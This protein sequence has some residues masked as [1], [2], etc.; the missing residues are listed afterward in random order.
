[1]DTDLRY[2]TESEDLDI[3]VHAV[4]RTGNY[5]APLRLAR[6]CNNAPQAGSLGKQIQGL[7]ERVKNGP[8]GTTPVVV[9]ST[10]YQP[11]NPQSSIARLFARLYER[12]G[13]Y[14]I[15]R[16]SE[17]RVMAA[18][19]P[20][21][22]REQELPHFDTWLR[23]AQPL[24][25]LTS[26][27][28]IMALDVPRPRLETPGVVDADS[29]ANIEPPVPRP[30]AEE[31]A[32]RDRVIGPIPD[33]PASTATV[34]PAET[35]SLTDEYLLVGY[36]SNQARQPVQVPLNSLA[37]HSAFLGST[38][39]GKTTAALNLIEQL[40]MRGI[41]ALLVDRK[42]D[43]INYA[44]DA[45]WN[46]TPEDPRL[47]ERHRRLGGTLDLAVYTPGRSDGRPVALSVAPEGLGQM[48]TVERR[49]MAL[50]SAHL[51]G[52]ML[53]YKPTGKNAPRIS[54]LAKA[55]D[56]MAELGYEPITLKALIEYID[57]R[58]DALLS[59]IGVLDVK[60]FA[61][62]LEALQ[63]LAINKQTLFPTSGE[64]LRA[65]NLFGLGP[66]A[67]QGKTRLCVITTKFLGDAANIHF[68]VAHLLLELTRWLSKEPA[69][70]LQAV[71]LFDEADLYLPATGKPAT[72]EPMES[73]L[74]RA[75]SAGLGVMLA[76]Q[77]SGDLDYNCQDNISTWWLGQIEEDATIRKMKPMLSQCNR[78]VGSELGERQT[79]EFFLVQQGQVTGVH[80]LRFLAET[81]PLSEHEILQ[82]A[83]GLC[84]PREI[85]LRTIRG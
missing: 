47:A 44:C 73:L 16:D 28:E 11:K 6:I 5:T 77:S 82:I 34:T 37:M 78:D 25:R 17:W 41:P 9:R 85:P 56:L 60:Q 57:G 84:P 66:S 54:I 40:L 8:A 75:R 32:A 10:E 55:I 1:M 76:T 65:E 79:G 80:S 36:T 4:S 31:T 19:Q 30:A 33:S 71:V 13:H 29:Q 81:H 72:K 58:D 83:R 69:S 12:E 15:V 49:Q 45:L 26:L 21:R 42:G 61:P 22:L 20:F 50:Q 7:L 52:G 51:L 3:E 48:K 24:V 27:R 43:L 59:A 68:W 35:S 74:K 67:Q 38:G 62:L 23:C 53:G 70:A 18:I 63:T 46:R 64:P 2:L 14:V 39:S